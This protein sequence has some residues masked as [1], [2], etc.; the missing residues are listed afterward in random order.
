MQRD[1]LVEAE[2]RGRATERAELIPALVRARVEL[3]AYRRNPGFDLA[4]VIDHLRLDGF[5]GADGQP[6]E[7]AINA[8]ID[9]LVPKGNPY[10]GAPSYDGGV[11]ATPP[12]AL[13]MNSLIRREALGRPRPR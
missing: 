13:D 1:P 7:A 8:A 12:R 10:V 2:A 3:A 5:V 11:R 6:D 4:R 9:A